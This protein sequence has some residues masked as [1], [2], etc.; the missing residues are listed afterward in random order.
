MRKLGVLK[1][2]AIAVLFTFTV[3]NIVY[4]NPDILTRKATGYTDTLAPV[5]RLQNYGVEL[6]S[7]MFL[8]KVA[9][10]ILSRG[11]VQPDKLSAFIQDEPTFTP[12]IA[13]KLDLDRCEFSGDELRI[14]YNGNDG[15]FRIN[16]YKKPDHIEGDMA[17]AP[18]R[19]EFCDIVLEI[20]VPQQE[21][22]KGQDSAGKDEDAAS[23]DED[24]RSEKNDDVTGSSQGNTAAHEANK[25]WKRFLGILGGP[26]GRWKSRGILG[27]ND[28]IRPYWKNGRPRKGCVKSP[29]M[30]DII[31]ILYNTGFSGI[32]Q[33]IL[34]ND[35]NMYVYDLGRPDFVKGVNTHYGIRTGS[36]HITKEEYDRL[37]KMGKYH[38]AARVV[39]E[40]SEIDSWREKADELIAEGK[41]NGL[42]KVPIK[43]SSA[44]ANGIRKWI[45]DNCDD[46]HTA[47]AQELDKEFHRRGVEHEIA[48]LVNEILV[49]KDTMSVHEYSKAVKSLAGEFLKGKYKGMLTEP[50]KEQDPPSG[51]FK[52]IYTKTQ[53]ALQHFASKEEREFFLNALFLN[54]SLELARSQNGGIDL[55]MASQE[56]ESYKGRLILKA[57]GTLREAVKEPEVIDSVTR[58]EIEGWINDL[59]EHAEVFSSKTKDILSQSFA[60]LRKQISQKHRQKWTYGHS[61]DPQD[62]LGAASQ[63][64]DPSSMGGD[65]SMGPLRYGL[66]MIGSSNLAQCITPQGSATTRIKDPSDVI[67]LL[68]HYKNWGYRDIRDRSSSARASDSDQASSSKDTSSKPGKQATKYAYIA[69]FRDE[70]TFRERVTYACRSAVHLLKDP[71]I[72]Q[73]A[74][75]RDF[76]VFYGSRSGY[77]QVDDTEKGYAHEL[78]ITL[79][80]DGDKGLTE[81]NYSPEQLTK[82]VQ[83][84][85]PQDRVTPSIRGVKIKV[86]GLNTLRLG[87]TSLIK[88][89]GVTKKQIEDRAEMQRL[90]IQIYREDIQV[91]GENLV[92][93]SN[94]ALFEEEMPQFEQK[95][96]QELVASLDRVV[97]R[98]QELEAEKGTISVTELDSDE[99]RKLSEIEVSLD[100]DYL[101]EEELKQEKADVEKRRSQSEVKKKQLGV[102]FKYFEDYQERIKKGEEISH[103]EKSKYNQLVAKYNEER[104]QYLEEV[105]AISKEEGR[106]SGEMQALRANIERKEKAA[107]DLKK[108]KQ[109]ASQ[110]RMAFDYQARHLDRHYELLCKRIEDAQFGH[111][112]TRGVVISNR[113]RVMDKLGQGGFGA[114]YR[115][116]DLQL[117]QEKAI[118]ILLPTQH[119][120][121][122]QRQQATLG[123]ERE[124]T[125]LKKL[126]EANAPVPVIGDRFKYAGSEGFV[127]SL[128]KG[129]TLE[130]MFHKI[131]KGEL[132]LSAREK[133]VLMYAICKTVSRF[134]VEKYIH[135]DFKP[136]NIIIPTNED[137]SLS[138]PNIADGEQLL[139]SASFDAF[140][141]KICVIDLGS[142]IPGQ[143]SDK[144]ETG[145][146]KALTDRTII[147]GDNVIHGTPWYIAPEQAVPDHTNPISS[148]TD[149]YSLGI[150]FYRMFSRHFPRGESANRNDPVQI[151]LSHNSD[152]P[153][154]WL[155]RMIESENIN[156]KQQR[157]QNNLVDVKRLDAI[158]PKTREGEMSLTEKLARAT[159][160]ERRLMIR[161][162][163]GELVWV[164]RVL[165][166]EDNLMETLANI[167]GLTDEERDKIFN[168]V[169][170]K[171]P[172][173]D[174][175]IEAIVH[176]MLIRKSIERPTAEEIAR[177]LEKYLTDRKD[178]MKYRPRGEKKSRGT[179]VRI[180][181]WFQNHWT[182]FA[183]FLMM[184]AVGL[185]ALVVWL[186]QLYDQAV[187]ERAKA[188]QEVRIANREKKKAFEAKMQAEKDVKLAERR[189]EELLGERKAI[190]SSLEILRKEKGSVEEQKASLLDQVKALS[191]KAKR[192]V[193]LEGQLK[194]LEAKV[195]SLNEKEDALKRR[196]QE[197][198]KKIE[199]SEARLD[200]AEEELEKHRRSL[201]G[202][203]GDA[204]AA[205]ANFEAD[206]A[207][208]IIDN[209]LFWWTVNE[210]NI[211]QYSLGYDELS[212]I[213]TDNGYID[214]A[215][216][217]E[218][219]RVDQSPRISRFIGGGSEEAKALFRAEGVKGKL[220]QLD[221]LWTKGDY[222][223]ARKYA[224]SLLRDKV[225]TASKAR[226]ESIKGKL[227]EIL[228]EEA[229]LTKSSDLRKARTETAESLIK[230]LESDI[231]KNLY[232]AK[233]YLA[234]GEYRSAV[235]YFG[236]HH[237]TWQK[238]SEEE[239]IAQGVKI[240]REREAAYALLMQA[241][242]Y[243]QQAFT[244]KLKNDEDGVNV[245]AGAAYSLIEKL[246]KEYP[247]H[248]AI[249]AWGIFIK[250]ELLALQGKQPASGQEYKNAIGIARMVK[251]KLLLLLVK[252]NL[253][254]KME[255]TDLTD[256]WSEL[257]SGK[258]PVPAVYIVEIRKL[259]NEQ[260]LLHQ[261]AAAE[262][263]RKAEEEKRK[264]EEAKRKAE[265]EEKRALEE[266]RRKKAEE[267]I[268]QEALRGVKTA[269]EAKVRLVQVNKEISTLER[270]VQLE[271]NRAK[272]AEAEKQLERAKKKKQY[273]EDFMDTLRKQQVP[274]EE[275]DKDKDQVPDVPDEG[276]FY[277]HTYPWQDSWGAHEFVN[278]FP[279]PSE[280]VIDQLDAVDALSD[281]PIADT[282]SDIYPDHRLLNAVIRAS[283][284]EFLYTK[285]RRDGV[286]VY[287][288]GTDICHNF[289]DLYNHLPRSKKKRVEELFEKYCKVTNV[290]PFARMNLYQRGLEALKRIS[291]HAG[292]RLNT[293]YVVKGSTELET[294]INHEIAEMR[295][296]QQ[297]AAELAGYSSWDEVPDEKTD[298]DT[299]IARLKDT[300][301]YREFALAA[302]EIAQDTFE[303]PKGRELIPDE[304]SSS[305][306]EKLVDTAKYFHEV[307]IASQEQNN[308]MPAPIFNMDIL[309]AAVN[310][311]TLGMVSL[312]KEET[313]KTQSAMTAPTARGVVI[314]ADD[315]VDCSAVFD[316]NRMAEI[317]GKDDS[318]LS[319]VVLYA[320]DPA[321]GDIVRKLIKDSNPEAV[322]ETVLE[323]DVKEHY[324]EDYYSTSQVAAVLRYSMNKKSGQLF[325]K[326]DQILGVV[327]GPL[328]N[329]EDA[330]QIEE[331]LRSMNVPVVAFED[332]TKGNVYSIMQALAELA[333]ARTS[334]K[335]LADRLFMVL[336]PMTRISEALEKEYRTFKAMVEALESAA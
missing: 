9:S 293:V 70:S 291:G 299:A 177:E 152:E 303:V 271:K 131:K 44:W 233:L 306:N 289:R 68:G 45:K 305:E 224:E 259:L 336:P 313:M 25:V 14:V 249:L 91:A 277:R 64:G 178:E 243:R 229:T 320:R 316:L 124:V 330:E 132:S 260:T 173:V 222:P 194:E 63:A 17:S 53:K 34:Q 282:L 42:G 245:A 252:N 4:A 167:P 215:I 48:I 128:A 82:I 22:A 327:R 182:F 158:R 27:V 318:V 319:K 300:P 298:R 86:V 256:T 187:K 205:A 120:T 322:V 288:L 96:I 202:V 296:H 148:K 16:F 183:V 332:N 166:D 261:E 269:E 20:K 274:P 125:S 275:E 238:K 110:R 186:Y 114:V 251:E 225:V 204:K 59:I 196:E 1:A 290:P 175:F 242:T 203:F 146:F 324:G 188:V 239:G 266:A 41:I 310:A 214:K 147:T 103:E 207:L 172:V 301:G 150:M 79:V 54:A 156:L 145:D 138:L 304:V 19:E 311:I 90:F 219:K 199:E 334:G 220:K 2:I 92:A 69:R 67:N 74:G 216:E 307:P 111:P 89:V 213:L 210:D 267:L 107:D 244:Y 206:E 234:R 51:I 302:H 36:I 141:R 15:P 164:K 280:P 176:R 38:L 270:N 168:L 43:Y 66:G 88:G 52:P 140:V 258:I 101:R 32:A 248:N 325:R 117:D 57:V 6:A 106:I 228:L 247:K 162:S 295:I 185:A 95:Y 170:Q 71:K 236:Y 61:R 198:N 7:A 160:A 246:A 142:A 209:R 134:H 81:Y 297:R 35:Y 226:V 191:D 26:F 200:K 321:K 116:K 286:T 84:F 62:I 130:E 218:N 265:E 129:I 190:E 227:I 115:V 180:A 83:E 80:V 154:T 85:S 46:S 29:D 254:E 21:Y 285:L 87:L 118:K 149:V 112:L 284:E 136:A 241:V 133:I 314:F 217:L 28:V 328:V 276:A 315:L 240:L 309:L 197:L 159:K 192:A 77:F 127:M 8:V 292:R 113:Y 184:T 163:Q 153:I 174:G 135:R 65:T 39:H 169:V 312:F 56:S 151:V 3:Q 317:V 257:V 58:A 121:I 33:S 119:M 329:G 143:T 72:L 102:T 94:F 37:K 212:K 273:L 262:E 281:M 60:N 55:I 93:Q 189:Q 279:M 23:G 161:N 5:S 24:I 97:A 250:G 253:G 11:D 122:A 157:L 100:S 201:P 104:A 181:E 208:R 73:L 323:S 49:R 109:R 50:W 335:A 278:L 144:K 263:K 237:N 30:P 10:D 255:L 211:K 231:G 294:R 165:E 31:N 126:G 179:V 221:L 78:D 98:R 268:R 75:S 108:R 47:H 264:A 12:E 76:R 13:K 18:G 333:S 326:P 139:K 232:Y 195:R 331:D 40:V 308:E 123:F 283:I 137:G 171:V 272:R 155:E 230:Q 223:G 193:E 235:K 99:E 287:V 105:E